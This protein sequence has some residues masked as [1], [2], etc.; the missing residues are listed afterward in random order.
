[1]LFSWKKGLFNPS[2]EN[3]ERKMAPVEWEAVDLFLKSGLRFITECYKLLYF[4]NVK[5]GARFHI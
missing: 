4:S 3:S 2:K 5:S 1:M